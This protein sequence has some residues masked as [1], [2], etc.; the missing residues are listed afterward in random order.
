MVAAAV[1]AAPVAVVPA[2]DAGKQRG[3][4]MAIRVTSIS[5]NEGEKLLQ[6]FK[7]ICLRSGLFKELKRRQSYEKPSERRRREAN[8]HRRAARR[9]E[10]R[11]AME[12]RK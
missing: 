2:A 9:A 3:R 5:G 11:K 10:R 6:R 1:A 12:G 8:E 7:R 4:L